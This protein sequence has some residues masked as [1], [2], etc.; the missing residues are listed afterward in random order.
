MSMEVSRFKID[1]DK[2]SIFAE[3]VNEPFPCYSLRGRGFIGAM[4]WETTKC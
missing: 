4:E 2:W 3:V 1:G